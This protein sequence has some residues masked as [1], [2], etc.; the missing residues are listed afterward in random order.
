[1]VPAGQ[2]HVLVVA[3]HT[4]PVG[5]VHPHAVPPKNEVMEL[6]PHCVQGGW[7]VGEK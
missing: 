6:G 7:P 3:F 1:V 5:V 4:A 2:A